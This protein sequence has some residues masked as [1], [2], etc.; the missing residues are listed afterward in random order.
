MTPGGFFDLLK[1]GKVNVEAPERV[2]G[3]AESGAGLK[4]ESG[5][6]VRTD[7]V[8]LATGYKSSWENL[9]DGICVL[10]IVK[11]GIITDAD[12]PLFSKSQRRRVVT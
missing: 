8:V 6:V 5:K 10:V 7:A 9:F 12:Y 4:L 11:H 1:K 2:E 3:F